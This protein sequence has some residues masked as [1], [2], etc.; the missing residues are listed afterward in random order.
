MESFEY[1]SFAWVAV[2]VPLAR[3]LWHYNNEM[4]ESRAK[5]W[6]EVDKVQAILS[7]IDKRLSILEDRLNNRGNKP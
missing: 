1:A 7:D 6:M 5:L 3:L 4:K 2:V